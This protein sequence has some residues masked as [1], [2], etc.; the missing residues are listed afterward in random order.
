MI[1]RKSERRSKLLSLSLL[2]IAV[3]ALAACGAKNDAASSESASSAGSSAPAS[4]PAAS[5]AASESPSASPKELTKVTQVTNW[6][7]EPE[8][9]GQYAALA[10]GFYKDAGLDMTIQSGGPGVSS[11]QLVGSGKAEFGM[12]QADEILLARQNG[13]PLV[14][15]AAIFQKNPQGIMFHKGK[16]KNPSEL[17]GRKVYVSS[18]S[19][20]WEFLKK[21]YKLDKVQ[22]LKY[23]GS[24]ANFVADPEA[25][26]QIYIT[27][28]PFTMQ[29]EKVDVDYF[30]NYD[31]GYKQ[32]GNIL[33]TTEDYLKNHP[34]IVKAYVEASIKG[35]TYYKDNAEE[36]NKVM[37]EKNP[38]LKLEAMAFGAEAQKPLIYE[39]DAAA[40]GIGYMSAD[41]WSGLQK[42]LIDLGI[43]K[44]EEPVEKAFTNEFLPGK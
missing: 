8:H 4:S 25:A 21:T 13:I 10:K 30:L 7:A 42:Q 35:W 43:L 5:S 1:Y 41:I 40:N 44:S 28:E 6:F 23:T 14:A 19:T 18:G 36:I 20:Y 9:G 37:Q 31:L 11:T 29:Q 2:L 17:N 12:G 15:I 24:L 16:I 3:L 32:Y 22:E 26:T 39:G 34:D 33:Y 27:S 38:D